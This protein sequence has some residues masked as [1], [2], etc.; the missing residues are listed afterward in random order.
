LGEGPVIVYKDNALHYHHP[1]IMKC[2]HAAHHHEVPLQT[3]IL[4]RGITDGLGFFVNAAAQ[5]VLLGCPTLYP[6]SPGET[7]DLS[8]L[9]HLIELLIHMLR[10]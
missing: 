4:E 7:I 2:C 8:D 6:H 5:S 3:G 1:L 10:E 9:E